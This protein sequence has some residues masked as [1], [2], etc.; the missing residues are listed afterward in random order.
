MQTQDNDSLMTLTAG[1]VTVL[2]ALRAG[3]T[4][5]P[6]D[7]SDP[8]NI[9]AAQLTWTGQRAAIDVRAAEGFV[10]GSSTQGGSVTATGTVTINAGPD[11]TGVGIGMSSGSAIWTDATGRFDGATS[12]W[13]SPALASSAIQINS[14]GDIQLRGAVTASDTGADIFIKTRSQLLIDGLI[15]AHDQLQITAG[16]HQ[17]G[18]AVLI[19]TLVLDSAN[20]RISG[21]T[22]DTAAGGTIRVN[23]TDSIFINSA[24]SCD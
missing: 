12:T 7:N 10:L 15:T 1:R 2:G 24:Y 11:D 14:D 3:A 5:I 16:T 6:A 21:G 8:N 13:A 23:A 17:S 9:I 4:L 20:E 18:V 19:E 22:L